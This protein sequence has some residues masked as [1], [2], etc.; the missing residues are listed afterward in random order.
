MNRRAFAFLLLLLAVVALVVPTGAAPLTSAATTLLATATLPDITL[1]AAQ[2]AVLPGSIAD[3]RGFFLG[4]IGSDLWRSPAD[5]AGEFWMVT[6]RGPNGQI[7][8][9]GGGAAR[10]TFPVPAFD[11]LILRVRISGD[12]L[13]VVE[14]I[15]ILTPSGAPVSGISNLPGKDETPYT[16][17]A[18][19]EL[20]FNPDGLDSEGL[21]RTASGEFWVAEEYRPS[22]V[23]IGTNG[24]V[25]RRLIPQGVTLAATY[26]VAATLP[27]ILDRRSNNRGFEGLA[28]TPDGAT[29]FAA[30][31]SP[32]SNPNRNVGGTSRNV[33]ILAVDPASGQPTAEYVYRFEPQS[34]FDPASPVNP[35]RPN[36]EMKI[37]GVIALDATT[38]YVLERTDLVAKIY[39]VR[40]AEATN[41]LGSQW[42]QL[43]TSPTLEELADPAA[44]GI[45]VVPKALVANLEESGAPDKIEG[46]A[47]AGGGALAIANDNDFNITA[48]GT[49]DPAPTRQR[50]QVRIVMPPQRAFLPLAA[51]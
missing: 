24:R 32:L 25:T 49:A 14:T 17:D 4:G 43:A 12:Q 6:D 33:R 42:D 2:N 39:R 7:P 47:L 1:A 35:A 22:L 27:A 3:D 16:F 31:Q 37:S 28:L 23:Q 11:P 50:S 19:T 30:V 34:A 13:Q 8:P 15:P 29:L 40:L 46:I 20:S 21:V 44:A 41:I 9:P 45:T 36:D 5:P 10:R 38:L 26:P 51:R 18:S 48:E